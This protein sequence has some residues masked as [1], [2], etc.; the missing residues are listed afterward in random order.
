MVYAIQKTFAE[1]GEAGCYF[2]CQVIVAS[3]ILC[4]QLDIL[5]S[6]YDSVAARLVHY[7]DHNTNDPRNCE[8]Q[9][10]KRLMEFLTGLN[11]EY[12]NVGTGYKP[13][14]DEW[15][16]DEYRWKDKSVER[17]HFVLPDYDPLGESNTRKNGTLHSR[18]IFLVK[19]V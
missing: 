18:R 19:E 14:D 13:T 12:R 3:R 10:S 1:I 2:L 11:I 8:V 15:V 5:N 7:D 9:D 16:I 6:F 17:T 4:K